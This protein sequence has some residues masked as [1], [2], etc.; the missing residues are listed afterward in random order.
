MSEKDCPRLAEEAAKEARE[1]RGYT[2]AHR[3]IHLCNRTINLASALSTAST[4]SIKNNFQ[5]LYL[6]CVSRCH[7]VGNACYAVR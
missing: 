2:G 4:S 3:W 7:R 1:L 5:R 6:R